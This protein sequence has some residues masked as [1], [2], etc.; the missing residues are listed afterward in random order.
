MQDMT[1]GIRFGRGWSEN[2]IMYI[3]DTYRLSVN[4]VGMISLLRMV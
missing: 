2:M 4:K 1:N 3:W